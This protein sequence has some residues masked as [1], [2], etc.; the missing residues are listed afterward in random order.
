MATSVN[1]S[2][3]SSPTSSL[4]QKNNYNCGDI[5]SAFQKA[6]ESED[7]DKVKHC[8][9]NSILLNNRDTGGHDEFLDLQATLLQG[10]S[11]NLFFRRL[12]DNLN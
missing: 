6:M 4:Q 12:I 3:L 7:C 8:L 1:G 11:L 5:L 10:S 2:D 9:E